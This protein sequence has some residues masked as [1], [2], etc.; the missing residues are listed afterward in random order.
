MPLTINI[1]P[2]SP[3]DIKKAQ[4]S[5]FSKGFQVGKEYERNTIE[6]IIR[7]LRE[8]TIMNNE[9]YNLESK[10]AYK[11]AFDKLLDIIQERNN[12]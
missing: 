5:E 9:A 2:P 6:K 10:A 4:N 11:M 7:I 3:E 1:N 12:A 8:S